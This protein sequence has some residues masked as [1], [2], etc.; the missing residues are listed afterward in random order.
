MAASTRVLVLGGHGKIALYLQPKLLAKNWHVTSVIRNPEHEK[1][2]LA[3]GK[4]QP[5]QIDVLIDSLDDVQEASQAQ[6]VLDKVKP[7]IVVW[8][9]G[10]YTV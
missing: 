7:N 5:G 6:S 8:S 1:E 4:N 9:A 3:L 10:T 2:I